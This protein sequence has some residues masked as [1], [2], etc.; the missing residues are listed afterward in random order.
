MLHERAPAAELMHA[1]L[2]NPPPHLDAQPALGRVLHLPAQQ[3]GRAALGVGP[4]R[5]LV[6]AMGQAVVRGFVQGVRTPVAAGGGG[7]ED[8]RWRVW[9]A[10]GMEC[11]SAVVFAGGTKRKPGPAAAGTPPLARPCNHSPPP[12]AHL[13]TQLRGERH[14]SSVVPAP[15]GAAKQHSLVMEVGRFKKSAMAA[16]HRGRQGRCDRH[17]QARCKP[18]AGSACRRNAGRPD[19]R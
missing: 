14:S 6:A 3:G 4:Q 11:W 8:R 1:L 5:V 16:G 15:P 17:R 10:G 2:L 19:Q 13:L 12:P 7:G 18:G 9:R